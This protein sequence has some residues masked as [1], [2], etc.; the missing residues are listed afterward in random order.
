MCWCPVVCRERHLILYPS[1]RFGCSLFEQIA[2]DVRDGYDD[3]DAAEVGELMVLQLHIAQVFPLFPCF[4]CISVR[5][6][7]F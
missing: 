5:E 7:V 4:L 2:S 1:I 3:V 6:E